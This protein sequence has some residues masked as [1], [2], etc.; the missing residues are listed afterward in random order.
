MRPHP[1]D[2]EHDKDIKKYISQLDMN[3]IRIYIYNKNKTG[4]K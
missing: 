3:R 4:Y 1:N 2:Y